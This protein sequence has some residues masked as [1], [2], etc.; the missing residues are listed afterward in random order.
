MVELIV[1]FVINIRNQLLEC[2]RRPFGTPS[3]VNLTE[4]RKDKRLTKKIPP[5]QVRIP[6]M[7]IINSSRPYTER[8]SYL[9]EVF[10]DDGAYQKVWFNDP[11]TRDRWLRAFMHWDAIFVYDDVL[12][13]RVTF[14]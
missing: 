12:V 7:P 6:V 9:V 14:L 13:R 8:M 4:E 11:E 3:R 2:H 1:V 5:S 10:H